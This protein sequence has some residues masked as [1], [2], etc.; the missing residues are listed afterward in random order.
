MKPRASLIYLA[1]AM[2]DV[3][4]RDSQQVAPVR[5]EEQVAIDMLVRLVMLGILVT[6]C[7]TLAFHS[8]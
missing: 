8:F 4:L 7:L 1:P 2:L 6:V 5:T 3:R